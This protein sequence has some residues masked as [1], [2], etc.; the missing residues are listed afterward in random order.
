MSLQIIYLE[1]SITKRVF[2]KDLIARDSNVILLDEFDKAYS[3][4]HSAFISYL[5]REFMKIRIIESM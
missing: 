2:A 1:E 5:M 3:V 4:F